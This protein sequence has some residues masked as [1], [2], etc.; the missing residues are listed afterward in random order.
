MT[1]ATTQPAFTALPDLA[2]RQLGGSVLA[3]SDELFAE[4]ENLI[5]PGPAQFS[6]S[7]YGNKGKT[8]DG[9]ETRRRRDG[10]HDWAIVRLGAPGVVRGVV[11]DTAWF[12]GNFPP[13][14]SV[15]AIGAE[16]YPS[17][18]ELEAAQWD[19]LVERAPLRGDTVNVFEV[20]ST[21]RYTHVRLS[22]Y[23]DGGVARFRVHG[24]VVADPRLLG[25][26]FDL[27]AMENGGLVVDC[28]NSFY[29]SASNLIL[30]GIAHSTGEGWENARRREPGNEHVEFRLAA[31]GVVRIAEIDARNF[32]GNAPAAVELLGRDERGG[33]PEQWWPLL[34]RT[35]L[36]PDTQ[37]RFRLR[38]EREVTH[39][40][41]EVIPDGGLSRVR[42]CGTLSPAGRD[43]VLTRWFAALPEAQARLLLI[44]AD[45]TAAQVDAA[46]ARQ[47]DLSAAELR[48][49]IGSELG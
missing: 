14:A 43:A 41:M 45:R 7:E 12:A 36:Q 5:K 35:D 46:L 16:G 23:P 38:A 40:R 47:A 25:E 20:T 4:R 33:A 1:D 28:S 17:V 48:A 26:E 44:A 18:A 19:V 29:T 34:S 31:P 30:P 39:V 13:Y 8:Y 49:L 6:V 11:I 15:E 24:D 10:G 9:W 42:L 22:V 21:R 2:A 32:V 27:V 37:H 3:A